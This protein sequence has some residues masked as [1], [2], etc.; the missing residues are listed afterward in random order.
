MVLYAAVYGAAGCALNTA[1]YVV[2]GQHWFSLAGAV[3]CG[4]MALAFAKAAS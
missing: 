3:F 2:D 1:L 4:I